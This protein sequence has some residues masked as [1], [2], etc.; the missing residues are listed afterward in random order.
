MNKINKLAILS[1]LL[2]LSN[3]AVAYVEGEEINVGAK[4]SITL[5]FRDPNKPHSAANYID[6]ANSLIGGGYAS[7]IH[8]ILGHAVKFVPV[9]YLNGDEIRVLEK[10]D[11]LGVG[12]KFYGAWLTEKDGKLYAAMEMEKLTGEPLSKMIPWHLESDKALLKLQD[13]FKDRVDGKTYFFDRLFA[14]LKILA[15]N[16]ISYPD[17]HY[18][19]MIY[20]ISNDMKLVDFGESELH[21]T[22]Q[23]AATRTLEAEYVK[24]LIRMFEDPF[25]EGNRGKTAV[26][27]LAGLRALSAGQ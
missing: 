15:D 21:N 18:G 1:L 26:K 9:N 11:T 20:P 8:E 10:V 12:P 24:R 6:T 7:S 22:A 27:D 16:K 4:K 19:N 25:M 2:M 13:I 23:A 3:L 17:T 14:M 5:K